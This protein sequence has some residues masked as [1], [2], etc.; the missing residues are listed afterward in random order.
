MALKSS[1]DDKELVVEGFRNIVFEGGGFGNRVSWCL[2][3]SD[4]PCRY[5][6]AFFWIL[7]TAFFVHST[8]SIGCLDYPIKFLFG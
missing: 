4:G 5:V 1:R 7:M 3:V 6:F 8:L 2:N